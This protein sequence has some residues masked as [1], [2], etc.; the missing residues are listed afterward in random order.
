MAGSVKANIA[1]IVTEPGPEQKA[2]FLFINADDWG[3]NRETTDL[4]LE[5]A[6]RGTVHSVSA[7][8]WMDDSDRAAPLA[9][10]HGLDAGLH[11]NLTLPFSAVDCPVPVAERQRRICDYLRRSKLSRIV[12]NPFLRNAFEYVVTAQIEE[13]TRL[14]G[15]APRRIDGHHHMHLCS[16]V[17][18]AELLPPGIVVRRNFSFASGQ[19]NF[20]NRWYRKIVDQK[21]AR[22][23]HLTDYFYTLPPMDVPGRLQ[24]IVSLA[25]DFSVE[26]ETH[27]VNREEHEFLMGEEIA[28]LLADV[29]TASPLS[30]LKSGQL[31][32]TSFAP[33][34]V[35]VN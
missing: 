6:L 23:H 16:N 19:K 28:R 30:L 25:R 13:F 9:R 21:L 3:R 15:Q 35:R 22:R 24:Q 1:P 31:I 8:V 34:K 4:T 7:M 17:L 27:P 33:S 2:G 10:Q 5:C 18:L 26:L 12:Y 20:V 29:K 32:D 11:L 14:Y